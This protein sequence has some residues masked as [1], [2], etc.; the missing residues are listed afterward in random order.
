MSRDEKRELIEVHVAGICFK[1]T[2][3]DIEVLIAKRRNDR[4]L[5]PGKWECGGGQVYPGENFHEAI[6]RQMEDEL[7]VLVKRSVVF[8]TYVIKTPDLEQKIIP[9][10]KFIC[11][12]EGYADGQGPKINTKEFSE[13]K[14]QP[15]DNLGEI[16][17][18]EGIPEDIKTGWEFYNNCKHVKNI[19]NSF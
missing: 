14:W 8:G 3:N 5:L 17:F 7:G 11:F 19:G 18:I 10:I 9:G 6:K 16:D 12:F 13:W 4:K 15:I 1:E 2:P